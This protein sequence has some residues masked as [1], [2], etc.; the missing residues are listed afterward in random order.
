MQSWVRWDF[1]PNKPSSRHIPA[2]PQS[3]PAT[4]T[5][6]W[7]CCLTG[8]WSGGRLRGPRRPTQAFASSILNSRSLHCTGKQFGM[9]D[10]RVER[11]VGDSQS[12]L[13]RR[14]TTGARAMLP[15]SGH[16]EDCNGNGILDRIDIDR[17]RP[18][19]RRNVIEEPGGASIRRSQHS[20]ERAAGPMSAGARSLPNGIRRRCANA[21]VGPPGSVMQSSREITG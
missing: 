21:P 5:R 12:A 18:S 15:G 1:H 7:W 2:R 11:I 20:H 16:V 4:D 17:L 10:A 14:S 6:A 13:P 8:E 19:S 3:K 9:H